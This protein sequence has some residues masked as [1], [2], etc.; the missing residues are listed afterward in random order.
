[1]RIVS[2]GFWVRNAFTAP[3]TALMVV[4]LWSARY[5]CTGRTVQPGFHNPVPSGAMLMALA[6]ALGSRGK[7]AHLGLPSLNPEN[8]CLASSAAEATDSTPGTFCICQLNWLRYSIV[9]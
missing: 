1:M 4:A 8:A 5:R 9:A 6:S 2:L 7:A 3:T